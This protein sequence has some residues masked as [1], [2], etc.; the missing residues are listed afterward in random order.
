MKL[1][2]VA[3]DLPLSL[4]LAKDIFADA[5]LTNVTVRMARLNKDRTVTPAFSFPSLHAEGIST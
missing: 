5:Y 2:H 4:H 3:G 1:A